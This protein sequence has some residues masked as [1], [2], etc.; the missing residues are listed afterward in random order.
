MSVVS[1]D[2]GGLNSPPVAAMTIAGLLIVTGCLRVSD[3]RNAIDLQMLVTIAAALGLGSALDK[4][5]AARNIAQAIV[6]GVG[7]NPYLLLVVIYL[8]TI[9]FTEMITN[10][11]VAAMLFPLAV[12]VAA[13]SGYSPRPFIIAISL[14]ASLSFM[15]PVGYQTNLMV[16][17]PGGYRPRDYLRCGLPL[18]IAV[19]LTAL[20]LIPRIWPFS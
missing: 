18:S 11:A 10:N 12:A 16:M 8:V 9:V 5:G 14:A 13:A 1:G 19:T 3:A 15:T 6:A 4:S 20:I 2:F 17:G 7:D